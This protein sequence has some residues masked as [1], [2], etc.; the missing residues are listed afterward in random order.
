M[1]LEIVRQNLLQKILNANL[2]FFIR[3]FAMILLLENII[4]HNVQS[5]FWISNKY[6]MIFND[7]S[8]EHM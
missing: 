5:F 7:P 3:Y 4:E 1:C 2:L 6:F 8:H